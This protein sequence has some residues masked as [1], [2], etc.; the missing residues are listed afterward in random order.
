MVHNTIGM[1]NVRNSNYLSSV[2]LGDSTASGWTVNQKEMP[3][4]AMLRGNGNLVSANFNLQT[5]IDG[6]D[7]PWSIP[8]VRRGFGLG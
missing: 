2:F 8:V 4:T 7:T 5:D 6:V 3:G 1:V